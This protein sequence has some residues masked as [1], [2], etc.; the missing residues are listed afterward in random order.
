MFAEDRVLKS[1]LY[2][3]Y[4][5]DRNLKF[6]WATL[7]LVVTEKNLIFYLPHSLAFEPEESKMAIIHLE[8]RFLERK[9]L[10]NT[11]YNRLLDTLPSNYDYLLQIN[12]KN[13]NTLYL[14][15]ARDEKAVIKLVKAI[16]LGNSLAVF[17]ENCKQNG[18]DI[19]PSV[20]KW[21]VKNIDEDLK[22]VVTKELITAQYYYSTLEFFRR[23]SYLNKLSISNVSITIEN[24][25]YFID[26]L[27]AFPPYQIKEL[28]LKN[29]NLSSE[30]F[31]YLLNGIGHHKFLHKLSIKKNHLEDESLGH[32]E[33]LW[34]VTP[35]LKILRIT[36][37]EQLKGK[38]GLKEFL[39]SIYVHLDLTELDLSHNSLTFNIMET[40]ISHVFM[41]EDHTLKVLN[42]SFNQIQNK[43]Y[44]KIYQAYSQL[45]CQP[46]LQLILKPI[47]MY[48]KYIQLVYA[49]IKKTNI[50]IER[51]SI[52]KQ[53]KR[54]NL[55]AVEKKTIEELH[56]DIKRFKREN[57][58]IERLETICLSIGRLPFEYPPQKIDL[59]T[60]SIKELFSLANEDNDHYSYEILMRCANSVGIDTF[61]YEPH[62]KVMSL[63][64][65]KVIEEVDKLLNFELK[66]SEL[67]EKLDFLVNELVTNDI[68]GTATDTL[69]VLKEKRDECVSA[70]LAQNW[71]PKIVEGGAEEEDP[72]YILD[73]HKKGS[74]ERIRDMKIPMDLFKSPLE[75][76]YA[77][78]IKLSPSDFQEFLKT[79]V[80]ELKEEEDPGL[81]TAHNRCHFLNTVDPSLP[82][83]PLVNGDKLLMG[84]RVLNQYLNK[85][86]FHMIQVDQKFPVIVQL[87]S[88]YEI[89]GNP[90]EHLKK[91][92][93]E[94]FKYAREVDEFN[95]ICDKKIKD[96]AKAAENKGQAGD[97]KSVTG[98]RSQV[99]KIDQLGAGGEKRNSTFQETLLIQEFEKVK[100]IYEYRRESLLCSLISFSNEELV[101]DALEIS[102]SMHMACDSPLE[103]PE[104]GK[105]IRRIL[106][107]VINKEDVQFEELYDEI[108][109]QLYRHGGQEWTPES[110]EII[111]RTF[112]LISVVTAYVRPSKELYGYFHAWLSSMLKNEGI[113]SNVKVALV[114]LK[115]LLDEKYTRPHW[116]P[117]V[118]EIASRWH[119][120]EQF[121]LEI[122]ISTGEKITTESN[123]F[124]TV[125]ELTRQIMGSGILD[126]VRDRWVFGLYQAHN[127]TEDFEESALSAEDK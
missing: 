40:L 26:I 16:N 120:K 34:S 41:V 116:V 100:S 104:L 19:H 66:E 79:I 4:F 97:R 51:N 48:G 56:A 115:N 45:P 42:L 112:K 54:T 85:T 122:E 78:L 21:Y 75:T 52:N 22:Y 18:F 88:N 68:R 73:H 58:N 71:E 86:F 20:I 109:L 36:H 92:R 117:S 44:W 82:T 67:N 108:Y 101:T 57:E 74:F 6:Y 46:R 1:G 110:S 83:F 111:R 105:H 59:V 9:L 123:Y 5:K 32:F 84:V 98:R 126:L 119:G 38:T 124:T 81:R 15:S 53:K 60:D 118:A 47:P 69:L 50:V 96:K 91:F 31:K 95:Q 89:V 90:E 121:R 113:T 64:L 10:N 76:N 63:K 13:T 62:F 94:F 28:T 125:D 39:K 77:E 29:N 14:I 35:M 70:L 12:N 37:N 27:S 61:S 114:N 33:E 24:Y 17:K 43:Q 127:N 8:A 72:F 103:F 2:M 93:I 3:V 80:E 23:N 107:K 65:R 7:N 25:S 11:A 99:L 102:R 49:N 30:E 106:R 55:T 87:H